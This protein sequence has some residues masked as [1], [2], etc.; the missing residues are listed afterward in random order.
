MAEFTARAIFQPMNEQVELTSLWVASTT[1]LL[2]CL[3]LLL[4]NIID[5]KAHLTWHLAA[6]GTGDSTLKKKERI[7]FLLY[8]WETATYTFQIKVGRPFQSSSSQQNDHQVI[9]C[10]EAS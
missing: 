6:A 10:Y 3:E 1:D 2:F 7:L 8:S 5:A 4:S 9:Y